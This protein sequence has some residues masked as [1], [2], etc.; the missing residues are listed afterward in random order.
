MTEKNA[1]QKKQ[2]NDWLKYQ[3]KYAHGKLSRAI[4]LGSL[5]GLLMIIQ[6]AMLAYLIDLVIFPSEELTLANSL[7]KS[8]TTEGAPFS[9]TSLVSMAL[10]AIVFCRA[11]LGYFSASAV[12]TKELTL[13]KRNESY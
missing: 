5:N 10:V 6:T 4:A 1:Q 11:A 12:V 13:I 9:E 2:V 8:I 7:G 3:K